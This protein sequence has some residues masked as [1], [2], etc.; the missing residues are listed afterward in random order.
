VVP[1]PALPRLDHWFTHDVQEALAALVAQIDRE[2]QLPETDAL[3]LALSRIVVRVSNQDSDTRYAAVQKDVSAGQVYRLFLEAA[4]AIELALVET[5]GGLFPA[6]PDCRVIEADLLQVAPEEVGPVG[7]VITSPPY[8]NAY[9][10]WLYHKYRM[11]WLGHD[12]IA[13]R[14]AEIGARP[15]YFKK[16]HQ[17]EHDFERQMRDCFGLLAE[18]MEQRSYACFVVGN[19]IIHGRLIDNTEL[20]RRAAG[21]R[22]FRHVTTVKRPVHSGRKSFNLAHARLEEES[23]VIF[24]REGSSACRP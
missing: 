11:Y 22:G 13:V 20:L 4:E 24:R 9:E 18:V 8:P 17:T 6:E 1:I 16:N 2:P 14:E 12:P 23:I 5:Y 7:L 21:V 19:S 3:K 15:H 10:Y